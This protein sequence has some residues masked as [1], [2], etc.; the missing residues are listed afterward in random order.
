MFQP[1]FEKVPIWIL[2]TAAR[3]ESCT[4]EK[5]HYLMQCFSLQVLSSTWLETS[6]SSHDLFRDAFLLSPSDLENQPVYT[7]P[8]TKNMQHP[9]AGKLDKIQI[10]AGQYAGFFKGGFRKI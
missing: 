3:F 6:A 4:D 8:M 2:F 5:T 7:K 1:L 9:S 10:I